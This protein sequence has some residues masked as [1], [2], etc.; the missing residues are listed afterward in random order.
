MG[1]TTRA[2]AYPSYNAAAMPEQELT[3]LLSPF[4]ESE[5][6]STEQLRLITNYVDLLARWNSKINLTA[7][8]DREGIVTRHFG[9]SLFA[10]RHF[11]P[12]QMAPV[13]VTDVGSGAGFPGMPLKIWAPQIHLSLIESNG[14]KAT[15]LKEAIRMLN[16]SDVT[17]MP[18]RV[19]EVRTQCDL[20]TLRAIERFENILPF[21][22]KLLKP[23][24]QIGLLIGE[25]QIQAAKSVLDDF[26]WSPP[27]P[28]PLSRNRTI[29]V[30]RARLA[31]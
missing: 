1:R 29:L 14:K 15:F 7:I 21:L 3:Q 20:V 27:V 5:R 9:E 28:V 18:S 10:A 2:F 22:P 6:L 16:M 25:S 8:R 12:D 4:L 19:E 17:V 24:G 11:L 31:A 23:S 13:S 30:G 26:V